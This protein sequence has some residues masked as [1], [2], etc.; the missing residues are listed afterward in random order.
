MFAVPYPFTL[1]VLLQ[2]EVRRGHA[3]LSVEKNGILS[4]SQ[5]FF[6]LISVGI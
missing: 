2:A 1:P 4:N 6:I 3:E 5:C